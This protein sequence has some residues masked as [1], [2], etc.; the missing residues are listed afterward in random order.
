LISTCAFCAFWSSSCRVQEENIDQAFFATCG[1]RGGKR[2][3]SGAREVGGG[4]FFYF[5]W[6][7]I[8]KQELAR[9]S[10]SQGSKVQRF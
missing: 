4:F 6:N 5:S 8:S 7:N 2:R 3:W 1:A 10:Y 9:A